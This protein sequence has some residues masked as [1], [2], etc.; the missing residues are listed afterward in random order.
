MIFSRFYL[1]KANRHHD[2]N[3]YKIELNTDKDPFIHYT[4]M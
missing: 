3:D 2:V 1:S 4:S